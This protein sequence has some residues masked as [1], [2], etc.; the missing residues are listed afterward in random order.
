MNYLVFTL[1]AKSVPG[2]LLTQVSLRTVAD[3]GIEG[4]CRGRG[5]TPP[6][7]SGRPCCTDMVLLPSSTWCPMPSAD[8]ASAGTTHPSPWME[9]GNHPTRWP[10]ASSIP[11]ACAGPG[12]WGRA[13]CTRAPK[14][15]VRLRQ[16]DGLGPWGCWGH[17]GHSPG[18]TLSSHLWEPRTFWTRGPQPPSLLS[19]LGPP[20]QSLGLGD[21]RAGI[22]VPGVLVSRDSSG[23]LTGSEIEAVGSGRVGSGLSWWVWTWV[24]QGGRLVLEAMGPGT[25]VV[26]CGF[27]VLKVRVTWGP[28]CGAGSLLGAHGGGESSWLMTWGLRLLFLSE[29]ECYVLKHSPIPAFIDHRQTL[30]RVNGEDWLS[31]PGDLRVSQACAMNPVTFF[32]QADNLSVDSSSP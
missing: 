16:V 10:A 5:G 13:E 25:W 31:T 11:M 14:L 15:L 9:G 22:G 29:S 27:V 7:W 17:W 21:S 2:S 19:S 32:N 3:S 18:E 26:A 1:L 28:E 20:G 24:L 8:H 30:E 6:C 12:F 23:W 4:G